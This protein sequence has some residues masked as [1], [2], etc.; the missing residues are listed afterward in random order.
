MLDHY[1]ERTVDGKTSIV[2]VFDIVAIDPSDSSSVAA[3]LAQYDDAM[4]RYL[5]FVR[6]ERGYTSREPSDYALSQNQRWHQ[7]ALDWIA[8]RDDVMS[9]A[10]GVMNEFKSSG[11]AVSVEDFI[12]GMPRITWTA[13]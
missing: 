11:R 13:E 7:D 12:A 1:E 8:F 2:P 10:L 4:E 6:D 3:V 9:Y 5:Q